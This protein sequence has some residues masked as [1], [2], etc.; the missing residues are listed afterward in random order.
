MTTTRSMLATIAACL[1][2]SGTA[3]SHTQLSSSDPSDEAV[4]D[5]A[6]TEVQLRFSEA[7]RLTAVSV[8]KG[9]ETTSLDIE[10]AGPAAEFAVG[11]PELAPGEY[12][13]EWRALSQDTHVVSGEIRFSIAT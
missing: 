13:V 1:L 5:A 4:L 9:D 7:V 2:L 6:P 3:H 11:L 12:V 8:T 10:V